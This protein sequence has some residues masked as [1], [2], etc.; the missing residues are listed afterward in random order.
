MASWRDTSARQRL[1][2]DRGE[3]LPGVVARQPLGGEEHERRGDVVGMGSLLHRHLLT[4]LLGLLSRHRRRDEDRAAVR[5][6]SERRLGGPEVRVDVGAE[7]SVPLVV[8]DVGESVLRLLIGDVVH[9]DVES[10]ELLDGASDHLTAMGGFA[11]VARKQDGPPAGLLDQLG[12]VAGIVIL[13]EVRDRDVGPFLGEGDGDGPADARVPAG[14][15]R[16]PAV[17]QPTAEVVGHLVTGLRLHRLGVPGTGLLLRRLVRAVLDHGRLLLLVRRLP[18]SYPGSIPLR[19]GAK[20]PTG[21]PGHGGSVTPIRGGPNPKA[22]VARPARTRRTRWWNR[23]TTTAARTARPAATGCCRSSP[24]PF[25]W[26]SRS[27][28]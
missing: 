28:W 15:Q 4:E 13:G 19:T 1:A 27:C 8:V 22:C 21:A 18:A 9:Q 17:E 7:R 16:P 24:R 10:A 25:W 14:H 6:M 3:D 11:Q 2:A 5:K 23:V 20:H 26:A 12:R